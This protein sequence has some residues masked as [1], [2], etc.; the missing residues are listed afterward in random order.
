MGLP[1]LLQDSFKEIPKFKKNNLLPYNHRNI[2]RCMAFFQKIKMPFEIVI[3]SFFNFEKKPWGSKSSAD[4]GQ[5]RVLPGVK[6]ECIHTKSV[7]VWMHS[8][9]PWCTLFWPQAALFWPPAALEFYPQGLF[10]VCG[11]FLKSQWLSCYQQGLP[12]LVSLRLFP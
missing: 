3:Y 2:I 10:S 4:W 5:N 1:S 6:I 8:I 11:I 12:R 7:F 9:Y